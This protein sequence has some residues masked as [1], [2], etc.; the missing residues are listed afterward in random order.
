[1]RLS[2][3]CPPWKVLRLAVPRGKRSRSG[4]VAPLLTLWVEAPPTDLWVGVVTELKEKGGGVSESLGVRA[5]GVSSSSSS[6]LFSLPLWTTER[7]S[8]ELLS[9]HT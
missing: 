8:V 1:M 4:G 3:S 6:Y 7:R 2:R 5:G 9:V